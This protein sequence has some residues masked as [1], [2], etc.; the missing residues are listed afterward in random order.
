MVDEAKWNAERFVR[1]VAEHGVTLTSLVPAQVFDLTSAGL[2]PPP[3]LR[4]VIVGG[5]RLEDSLYQRARDLGWPVLPSYGMT[6]AASQIATA[7]PGG[8][9]T[10]HL[11]P[12]WEARTSGDARLQLRGAPLF[13]GRLVKRGD[14]WEFE[15]AADDEGWFTAADRVELQGR[16]LTPFGR[17]DRVVKVLGELV[18]LDAVEC[19]LDRAGL[20]PGRGAVIALPDERAGCRPWLVTELADADS[21][22]AAANASLPPFAAIAGIHVQPLPRSPLGKIRRGEITIP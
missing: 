16:I 3:S 6:E 12:C 2:T 18:D 11:L 22:V 19:A 21:F 10:M 13:S 15:P 9:A 20:P 7:M 5:G 8:D 17:C 4:A 14:G 1:L